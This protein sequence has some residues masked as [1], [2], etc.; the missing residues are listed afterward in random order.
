MS[1][2]SRERKP[3]T[4]GDLLLFFVKNGT[5][6]TRPF[7]E[8]TEED[9]KLG[10]LAQVESIT[11]KTIMARDTETNKFVFEIEQRDFF[12]LWWIKEIP[13]NDSGNRMAKI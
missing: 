7:D 13:Q 12:K 11:D 9:L 4:K 5:I 6:V 1:F 8:L 2:D 10:V 3:F